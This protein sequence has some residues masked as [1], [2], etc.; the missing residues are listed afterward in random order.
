[1]AEDPIT[2]ELRVRQ[3]K[4]EEDARVR[5]DE[6]PEEADTAQFDRR[7][8]KAAYLKRKLEER[9]DAEREAADRDRREAG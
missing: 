5:A 7:A 3:M 1:M 8:D 4:R 2:E 9:A 6:S